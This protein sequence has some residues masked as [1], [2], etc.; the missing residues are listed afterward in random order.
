M[1][2]R[3][4]SPY[5]TFFIIII[6]SFIFAFSLVWGDT[7][8]IKKLTRDA[9]EDL[10]PPVRLAGSLAL[11][12]VYDLMG[13]PLSKVY[14]LIV[15]AREEGYITKELEI[16]FRKAKEGIYISVCKESRDLKLINGVDP[17]EM[18]KDELRDLAL[19]SAQS[20]IRKM[21]SMAL[22]D[23]IIH[24]EGID[25]SSYYHFRINHEYEFDMVKEKL[26][27]ESTYALLGPGNDWWNNNLKELNGEVGF[28][29]GKMYLA[30]FLIT[31]DSKYV[32]DNFKC[33]LQKGTQ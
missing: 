21:A 5:V 26:E 32:N 33:P 3:K 14:K 10:V 25:F 16:A 30:E 8:D 12:R 24:G 1:A 9:V 11:V 23:R 18:D 31:R 27:G 7:K 20:E 4:Y 6:L 28:T 19:N 2:R 13:K 22:V 15:N 29:L 17:S